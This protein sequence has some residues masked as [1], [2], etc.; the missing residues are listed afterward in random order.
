MEMHHWKSLSGLTPL[1]MQVHLDL[2][3][4]VGQGDYVKTSS[5]GVRP[6]L[7]ILGVLCIC[8]RQ[9]ARHQMPSPRPRPLMA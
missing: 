7:M 5:T 3:V 1:S 8:S 6:E 4:A 9:W 2:W